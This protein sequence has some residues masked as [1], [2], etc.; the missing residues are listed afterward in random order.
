MIRG[1]SGDSL[2][3]RQYWPQYIRTSIHS[4]SWCVKCFLFCF[5]NYACVC[6]CVSVRTLACVRYPYGLCIYMYLYFS[7]CK[8]MRARTHTH[9]CTQRHTPTHARSHTETN[10]NTRACVCARARTSLWGAWMCTLVSATRSE[11]VK[12][13]ERGRECCNRLR[14]E[15]SLTQT[16]CLECQALLWV[17]HC[18]QRPTGWSEVTAECS[19]LTRGTALL[20]NISHLPEDLKY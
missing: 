12:E 3:S 7:I 11:N 2:Y 18:A 6:M 19:T 14:S 1:I 5:K 20:K 4:D 8:N 10:L 17:A 13:R 9:V 16:R 15:W